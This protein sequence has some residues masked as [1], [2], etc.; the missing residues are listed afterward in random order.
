MHDDVF[1]ILFKLITALMV[2]GVLGSFLT[3]LAYRL[4]R[5]LSIIEPAS[6][7]PKCQTPLKIMDLIPVASYLLQKGQCRYCKKEIGRRYLLIEI[8]TTLVVATIVFLF[9]PLQPF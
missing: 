3:M 2:G 7:C 9:F 5:K 4:P 6:H 8:L 1:F